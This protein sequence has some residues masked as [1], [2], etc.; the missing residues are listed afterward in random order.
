M[1]GSL[2]TFWRVLRGVRETLDGAV[3]EPTELRLHLS[4]RGHAIDVTLQRHELGA[5][6]IEAEDERS[7]YFG[8]G[9]AMAR[10]RYVQMDLAR[11]LAYGR[12]AELVGDLPLPK[13]GQIFGAK[14]VSDID[15]FI[16]G[17]RFETE[18]A[19]KRRN[20]KVWSK[21]SWKPLW[22]GSTTSC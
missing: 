3:P 17:F 1:K 4:W 6:I 9:Y 20:S 22:R 21:K 12:F 8:L 16:A 5:P 15:L 19:R 11:R 10:D 2:H 14:R 7:L 13:E 18:A